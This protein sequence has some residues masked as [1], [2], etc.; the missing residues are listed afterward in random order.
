MYRNSHTLDEEYPKTSREI[1][2]YSLHFLSQIFPERSLSLDLVVPAYTWNAA[3]SEKGGSAEHIHYERL[4]FLPQAHERLLAV[5]VGEKKAEINGL[6]F[7]LPNQLLAFVQGTAYSALFMQY[8]PAALAEKILLYSQEEKSDKENYTFDSVLEKILTDGTYHFR[9]IPLFA[10]E[11]GEGNFSFPFLTKRHELFAHTLEV[12]ISFSELWRRHIFGS[13]HE[14]LALSHFFEAYVQGASGASPF[15]EQ[16]LI[17]AQRNPHI[18]R[19][20]T[21]DKI[22]TL[23]SSLCI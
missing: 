15:L 10:Y 3:G 14:R 17:D 20:V 1:L 23:F 9:A 13:L 8:M 18:L 11:G 2:G 7:V 19:D 21:V 4:V 6:D 16:S 12:G 22:Q 5:S